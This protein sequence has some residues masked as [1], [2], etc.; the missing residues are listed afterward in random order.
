MNRPEPFRVIAVDCPWKFGDALPGPKR[1]ASKH[2]ACLTVPELARFPLPPLDADCVLVFWKVAA[3]P[4][5]ALFVVKAWGFKPKSEIVWVK[6]KNGHKF[7]P[8]MG[9]G[10]SVR[11]CHETAIIATR[12]KP[13]RSSASELS[14]VFAPRA[15]HSRKPEAAYALIERLY[16]GPYVELFGTQERAGWSVYGNGVGRPTP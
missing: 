16:P 2:Y 13:K 9:M 5:E 10:R 14:V 7:L 15:E 1:G 11:M 8:R 3:M 12:G 4:E 6:T